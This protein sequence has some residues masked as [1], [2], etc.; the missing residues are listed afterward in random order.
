MQKGTVR[1]QALEQE[2]TP[3][4]PRSGRVVSSESS[5]S[6]P[7]RRDVLEKILAATSVDSDVIM[8]TTGF[9]GRELYAIDDRPN[10]LYMVGSMGCASSLGLGL[11]LARPDLR[12]VVIDGDGAALMRMGAF[13][14]L[15]ALG[16]PNLVHLV[17]DNGV[18]DSTGGQATV[19]PRVS[20]AEVA[21]ACG[22]GYALEGNGVD[23]V[24]QALA[25]TTSCDRPVFGHILIEP[26]TQQDLPRPTVT[27]VEVKERLMKQIAAVAKAL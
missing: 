12:V 18:H 5:T 26:G 20:F 7:R 21:A 23:V 6:R 25:T 11:A 2:R 27:P 24:D 17:L 1:A 19:S 8:A 22:Y 15:G 4:R 14:T 9:T 10:H 16:P 13:A 3:P